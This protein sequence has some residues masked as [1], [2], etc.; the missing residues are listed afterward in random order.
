MSVHAQL[1]QT[2]VGEKKE[3][4]ICIGG[5]HRGCATPAYDP[6]SVL[7]TQM[8][9]TEQHS[10]R[11]KPQVS[12][13][14][15]DRCPAGQS[16]SVYFSHLLIPTQQFSDDEEEIDDAL[17][18]LPEEPEVPEGDDDEAE[19]E[20]PKSDSQIQ[21]RDVSEPRLPPTELNTAPPSPKPHPLSHSMIPD[22]DTGEPVDLDVP[23]PPELDIGPSGD[24]GPSGNL[25][26]SAGEDPGDLQ[27][28]DPTMDG[29]SQEV[30]DMDMIAALD[31]PL[32]ADAAAAFN[33]DVDVDQTMD[34]VAA[35]ELM[36]SLTSE[37]LEKFAS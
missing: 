21:S 29:M 26:P 7:G 18:P 3:W 36:L 30:L 13:M 31:E 34:S 16:S 28:L 27:I 24:L 8:D 35:D 33:V 12:Q 6:C 37:E 14:G 22:L 1:G 17:A 9:N 25:I 5:G 15:K 4:R 10:P 20:V 19:E 23:P 11:F 2:H 32:D